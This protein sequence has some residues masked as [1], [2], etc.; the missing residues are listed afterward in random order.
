MGTDGKPYDVKVMNSS[1]IRA[2]DK[3]SI[4][5]VKQWEYEPALSD[6]EPIEQCL[7]TVQIDYRMSKSHGVTKTFRRQ[8]LKAFEA[9]E[10]QDNK[11][12]FASIEN[13]DDY[14]LTKAAEFSWFAYLKAIEAKINGDKYA[15]LK[16]LNRAIPSSGKK[17]SYTILPEQQ[18][19]TSLNQIFALQLELNHYKD[20]LST[21]EK[22]ANYDTPAAKEMAGKLSPYYEDLL[23]YIESD[24]Q[25]AVSAVVGDDE[26]WFH[27]LSR[28]A[29]SLQ[30][31]SGNLNKLEVRCD[32][33]RH[34]YTIDK[35]TLWSIPESWG[36]CQLMVE[37]DSGS[38]FTL[39]EVN[40]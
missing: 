40:S 31:I 5:A 18:V 8:L 37:G 4:R 34:I 16:Y 27:N 12:L 22:I 25:I 29:F 35:D 14:Q 17:T 23:Q 3:A 32:K 36:S 1:G 24:N 21:Y 39:L 19:L 2:F 13:L 10:Q 26:L 7:T 30:S 6:G 38:E 33:K 20:A 11:A 28:S 9:L 15:Q